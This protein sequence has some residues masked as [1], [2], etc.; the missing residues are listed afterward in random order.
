MFRCSIALQI[1]FGF[2]SQSQ[3]V[4]QYSWSRRTSFSV[5]LVLEISSI[6]INRCIRI[7]AVLSQDNTVSGQFSF[8]SHLS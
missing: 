8:I 4:F 5:R 1:L 6:I 7:R 2:S 3:A